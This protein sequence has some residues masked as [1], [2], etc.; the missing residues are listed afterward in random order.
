MFTWMLE[1]VDESNKAAGV[2]ESK[3]LCA[4]TGIFHLW[5]K[6]KFSVLCV[7]D[8]GQEFVAPLFMM[9]LVIWGRQLEEETE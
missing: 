6:E 8:P 9:C 7:G 3:C 4:V 1:N 2:G 5:L